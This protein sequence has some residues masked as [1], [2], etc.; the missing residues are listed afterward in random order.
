MTPQEKKLIPKGI[1][2]MPRPAALL[3]LRSRGLREMPEKPRSRVRRNDLKPVAFHPHLS[4]GLALAKIRNEL[5]RLLSGQSLREATVR[6]FEAGP[7]HNYLG[8]RCE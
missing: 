8:K 5:V 4:M 6:H 2:T 3:S 7:L 1:L